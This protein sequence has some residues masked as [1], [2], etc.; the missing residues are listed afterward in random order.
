MRKLPLRQGQAMSRKMTLAEKSAQLM[1]LAHAQGWRCFVCKWPLLAPDAHPQ[2]AHRIPQAAWAYAKY[3]AAVIDH[4]LNMGAVCG[5]S[6][7][8]SD[9]NSAMSLGVAGGVAETRLVQAI[10]EAM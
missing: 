8:G 3:G 5:R 4:D 6:V 1:R 2:R 9:C 7:A 10:R